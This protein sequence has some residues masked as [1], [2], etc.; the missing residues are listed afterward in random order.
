MILQSEGL[1]DV[2]ETVCGF[3]TVAQLE[4]ECTHC[5]KVGECKVSFSPSRAR[6]I[7]AELIRLAN[8]IEN[9]KCVTTA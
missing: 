4:E 1:T 5:G 3:I 6:I 7:A 8:E 9:A 2:Y